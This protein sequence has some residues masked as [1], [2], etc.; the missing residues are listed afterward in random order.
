MSAN[1]MPTAPAPM[2][3]RVAGAFSRNSAS[4]EEM[5]VV[6][7]ISNPI[8]GRPFTRDPVAMITAFRALVAHAA[9]AL[10]G[11]A[12]IGLDKPRVDPELLRLPQQLRDVRRVE[13]RLGGDA[14]NVDAHPAKLVLLDHCSA[15]A[16]LGG[17]DGGDVAGRPPT[18]DYDVKLVCQWPPLPECGVWNA[19]CGVN[20]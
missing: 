9:R 4:S 12:V 7:L 8:C 1:S 19:E 6:L 20:G 13:Q 2:I 14:A 10:H 11:D 16:E 5:T 17:P 3:A 18:H 15:Q